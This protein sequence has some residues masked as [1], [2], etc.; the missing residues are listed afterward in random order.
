MQTFARF[1]R[2]AASVRSAAALSARA[3]ASD[4][5]HAARS[6]ARFC[7]YIAPGKGCWARVC[8]EVSPAGICDKAG[9]ALARAMAA[10]IR[11]AA[12]VLASQSGTGLAQNRPFWVLARARPI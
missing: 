5:A 11:A 12:G 10:L 7:F 1:L 6:L 3:A 9:A 8:S 2:S 4:G